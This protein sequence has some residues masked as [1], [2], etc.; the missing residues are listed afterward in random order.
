MSDDRST[1]SHLNPNS[2]NI[3]RAF[4]MPGPRSDEPMTHDY[5]ETYWGHNYTGLTTVNE[6]EGVI[7]LLGWGY[8][9][10]VGDFVLFG[11]KGGYVVKY[12]VEKIEYYPNPK[13][14]WSA[15]MRFEGREE[16]ERGEGGV[17]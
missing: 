1:S 6:E 16:G 9:I 5:T 10:R 15:E 2:G 11:G 7:S 17:E 3:L 14:M 12:R 13:D 8:D 4:G